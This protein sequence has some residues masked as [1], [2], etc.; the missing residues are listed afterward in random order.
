[1]RFEWPVALASLALAPLA[2]LVYV[3]LVRRRSRFA[4]R[5]TNLDVLASVVQPE[6]S[7]RRGIPPALLLLSLATVFVALARPEIARTVLRDESAVVLT[8]D[9]SGSMV[10]E[11][12]R[13]SR[14]GAAKEA[15]RRFVEHLDGKYRVGIVS[16]SSEPRVVTPITHDHEHALESLRF[17]TAGGGTAIGDA[18]RRSIELLRPLRRAARAADE[19]DRPDSAIILLTDGEQRDGVLQPLAAAARAS[20][21]EIPVYTVALGTPNGEVAPGRSAGASFTIPSD[22]RELR[23]IAGRTGGQFFAARNAAE[24]SSVYERLAARLRPT[25]EYR[26]AT[27]VFLGAAALLLLVAGVLSARWSSRLP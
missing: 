3:V 4:L 6:R 25:R 9:T 13:P 17:L 2:L 5:F 16:F 11:D 27:F 21:L 18:L 22:P 12:V 14:L 7:W 10:A 15:V 26:E 8:I 1:V 19:P 20:A 23:Q 24:L